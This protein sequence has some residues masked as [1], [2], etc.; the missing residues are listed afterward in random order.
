LN[1]THFILKL[2]CVVLALVSLAALA[3]ASAAQT[4]SASEFV[5]SRIYN[6]SEAQVRAVAV[7]DFNGDGKPDLV[8]PYYENPGQVAV[9]LGNGDGTFQQ[10]K[11]SGNAGALPDAL[12]VGDFN[13]DGKLDVVVAD[14][15]RG[16]NGTVTLMLGNGDG[17][18]QPGV[19][20]SAGLNPFAIVTGDF[21]NDGRLDVAVLDSSNSSGVA[22]VIIY[23]GNGKGSLTL[24]PSLTSSEFPSAIAT[25]D[26]NG[27]GN[28]DLVVANSRSDNVTVFLGNGNGT[29]QAGKNTYVGSIQSLVVADLNKDGKLDL[30][31][32]GYG[33]T[34]V[35]L[36]LGNGD[37]TFQSPSSVATGVGIIEGVTI[38]DVNGDGNPDLLVAG[39]D[40]SPLSATPSMTV[41][42][43]NG[44][45]TF[46]TA[47][48]YNVAWGLQQIVVADFNGDGNPDVAALNYSSSSIT[49]A[50]G[51]G[52]GTFVAAP[53][54][55]VGEGPALGFSADFNN[56][57][58]PDLA[59]PIDSGASVAVLLGKGD[60][61][62]P[63]NGTGSTS[64][65]VG[66]GSIAV[67]DF[68][69]DG[70]LDVASTN[71]NVGN[72]MVELGNG[73]GGFGT[74]SYY[75]ADD[76]SQSMTTADVNGDGILDL[77]AVNG[78]SNDV[79]VLLGN[80]DGTF[81][82]AVNYST[83]GLASYSIVL[84][85]FNGDKKLD[86]AVANSG[87]GGTSNISILL[88][89]GDGTFG[90]PTIIAQAAA[91][92]TAGDVNGDGF[93]DLVVTG[94]D[95]STYTDRVAVLLG[96]GDG[97]FKSAV[98]YTAGY[99][100]WYPLLADFNGDGKLDIAAGDFSGGVNVL[101]G[102]GDGTFQSAVVY[103]A[104]VAPAFLITGDFNLDGA[105]DIAAVNARD[106]NVSV[107]LNTGGTFITTTS[108]LNPSGVGQAVTFT[109]KVSASIAGS[110]TPTGSVTFRD[111]S[112]KIGTVTLTSGSASLT[113]STLAAGSHTIT[114]AYSGDKNFNPHTG[115]ALTQTVI[116]GPLV[117]LNPT[118]VNFGSQN[119]GPGNQ[120]VLVNLTNT[121]VA[122]LTI[123]SIA[124]TGPDAS[125]FSQNN[126][127]G[128]SLAPG[129]ACTI[130]VIFSPTT[131][132]V[133]TASLSITDNAPGSPQ[134]VSLTGTGIAP[135]VQL[136]PASLAFATQLVGTSSPSQTVTLTNTGTATLNV[137]TISFTGA[138]AADFLQTNTCGATLA[139]GA[140]CSIS[141][142]FHPLTRGLRSAALSIA[143][144]AAGS[145][146]TAAV[147]GTA[148]VVSLSATS[149]NFGS[150]PVG[151]TSGPNTLTLTNTGQASLTF[152]SITIT[153]ANPADFAQTNTCGS[154]IAAGANCTLSVTFT[155]TKKGSR[156]ATL[157][158][159]DS[160]GGSPQTVSLTG[161]GE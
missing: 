1:R 50:L 136:S 45:G 142:V 131:T 155:P 121:G 159:A 46:Q 114:A 76:G 60:G 31:A 3:G 132:G 81:R 19:S 57:G 79:S 87:D 105:I 122:T 21:N 116:S 24:A 53:T 125:D 17:T 112:K 153:G 2:K 108:S 94:Y 58:I 55:A 51:K 157:S 148:T 111:G 151:K 147:S 101:L 135:A 29:F 106:G 160:G 39:G 124:I 11:V 16:Y 100:P 127:C 89:N 18:F 146:Q 35:S 59:I 113:T 90:P 28:L 66:P 12:A 26:F 140:S 10:P 23:L 150:E 86:I 67:G 115:A 6:L 25:G 36:L 54:Y 107:L 161:T 71:I 133:R 118:S 44:N 68:N 34:S 65:S 8:V 117:V 82:S 41:L 13:G 83:G 137:S 61:T 37:G 119:V 52:E 123:S 27:D 99:S 84:A 78:G 138:D 91:F 95:A 49:V 4:T 139:V 14:Y 43:G 30:V 109:A 102:N 85:D 92:V 64:G 63:S 70:N 22:N 9:L 156:S 48:G 74:P 104:A 47:V 7:G 69:R 149:I 40:G 134:T 144:N 130:S 56:D 62:F 72:L 120:G 145:P 152:Q 126:L 143:D 110:A 141:V 96:N 88:G 77:I 93:V 32:S 97:T 5:A 154:A 20:Y 103:G 75:I 129:F 38:S 128:S 42:F 98:Y 33:A 80:G 73:K 15:S 158:I